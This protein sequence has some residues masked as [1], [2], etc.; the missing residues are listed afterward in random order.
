M[1]LLRRHYK[2]IQLFCSIV[3][4]PVDDEM[5]RETHDRGWLISPS[6][7]WDVASG[8]HDFKTKETHE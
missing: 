1:K 6:L 8:I 5:W 7:A 2:R 4:R 3:W